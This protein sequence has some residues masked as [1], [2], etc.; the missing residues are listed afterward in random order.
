MNK[1]YVVDGF[2]CPKC[3]K[4]EEKKQKRTGAIK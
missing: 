1:G 4:L 2:Y 3:K